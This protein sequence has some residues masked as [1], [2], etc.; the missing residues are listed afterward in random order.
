MCACSAWSVQLTLYPKSATWGNSVARGVS[1]RARR[2][3]KC[4]ILGQA[5]PERVSKKCEVGELH[6]DRGPSEV[7]SSRDTKSG[8]GKYFRHPQVVCHIE[9][10][11]GQSC[12]TPAPTPLP[13]RHSKITATV[14]IDGYSM[15]CLLENYEAMIGLSLDGFVL[16]SA[17]PYIFRFTQNGED[18]GV[19][20]MRCHE[21]PQPVAEA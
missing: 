9:N 16:E 8:P 19:W 12:K 7:V 2:D 20:V 14:R 6:P 15:F 13:E 17:R 11:D 10:T 1:S 21:M 4:H 18:R 5:V 3:L